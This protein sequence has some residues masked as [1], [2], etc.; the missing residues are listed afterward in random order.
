MHWILKMM[1]RLSLLILLSCW[2]SES[3][4][5]AVLNTDTTHEVGDWTENDNE[6]QN[7]STQTASGACQLST[8]ELLLREL[9][10]MQE[11]MRTMEA[12]LE[13]SESSAQEL[14]SLKSKL[15]ATEEK[16]GIME[17]KLQAY[18]HEIEELKKENRV[19]AFSASVGHHGHTGPYNVE[20]TLVYKNVITNIGNVYNPAT[21]IFTA[22][23]RGMYFFSIYYHASTGND[24]RLSLKKNGQMLAT[25]SHARVNS[26]TDNG[27]NGVTVQ[28]EVG[29]QVY[30]ILHSNTWVWDGINQ[31]TIFSGF[32][33]ST[34]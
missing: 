21:G 25:A 2:V 6:I 18:K 27:S 33:I 7:Y 16:T 14:V 26:G 5:A 34:N 4:A 24:G 23:V 13:A 15:M 20:K 17:A 10:A 19:V 28:M 31:D 8:C 11:K 12:K 32:L 1:G 30:V 9:G 22:P 3:A 29:E